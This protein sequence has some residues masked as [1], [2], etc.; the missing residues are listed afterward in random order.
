VRYTRMLGICTAALLALGAVVTSSALAKKYSVHTWQQYKYCP[1]E[2]HEYFKEGSGDEE[3]F[4][5]TFGATLGGKAGG[6]FQLGRVI[7]PLTKPV[8]IQG[9][10]KEL[11]PSPIVKALEPGDTLEAP[12]LKVTKGI[13]L[14]TPRVMEEAGWSEELIQ[15]FDEAKANKETQEYVKIEI[16]GNSLYENEHAVSALSIL[17][18]EGNAFELPLKVKITGPFLE[19]LGTISCEVGNDEFPILQELTS[20][21]AGSGGVTFEAGERP[22]NPETGA[23]FGEQLE[24]TESRLVDFN[25][26]VPEGAMAKGCGGPEHEAEVD[27]A[28]DIVMELE[29][30]REG[31][32]VLT[33]DLFVSTPEI[34]TWEREHGWPNP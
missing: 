5:C 26:P 23:P 10:L 8:V 4:I 13:R 15:K 1:S 11:G 2:G 12:E 31:Y 6:Q 27:R 21:G 34:V 9:G 28:L 3:Y 24:I 33:G 7:V 14:I 29:R 20:H 30:G 18:E 19:K 22:A 25:W 32:T 16:G 17:T